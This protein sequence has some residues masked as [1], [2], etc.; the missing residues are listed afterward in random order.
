M[1]GR[2]FGTDALHIN[3]WPQGQTHQ[4][5]ALCG[6]YLRAVSR[7]PQNILGA[8]PLFLVFFDHPEKISSLN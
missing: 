5:P 6:T 1:F 8:A 3:R 4:M 7:K 2:A